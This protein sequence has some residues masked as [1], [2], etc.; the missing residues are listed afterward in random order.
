MEKSVYE[1]YVKKLRELCTSPDCPACRSVILFNGKWN[2]SVLFALCQSQPM[3]F[4]ALK[5]A[6]PGITNT[7][8][9][10]TL[11][12]LERIGVVGREQFNEIPP[13]VEYFLTESGMALLPGFYE[14]AK[15]GE[16][17]LRDK[18]L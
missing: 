12:E 17:Y 9:S 15:W 1:H 3:R 6:V 4:G 14:F 5:R 13:H 8:L 7:M 18:A 2:I 10:A 16:Q 11:R